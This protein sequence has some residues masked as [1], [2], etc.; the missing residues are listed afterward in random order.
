MKF[1]NRT[2]PFLTE[3]GQQTDPNWLDEN[4]AIYEAHVRGPFVDVA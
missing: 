4:Q 1:S 3:A 2:L